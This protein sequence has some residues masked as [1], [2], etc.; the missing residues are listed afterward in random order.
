MGNY[1]SIRFYVKSLLGKKS[2]NC[3]FVTFLHQN[4]FWYH[5]TIVSTLKVCQLLSG[6]QCILILCKQSTWV[7]PF[8]SFT[9]EKKEWRIS[10][11]LT[12]FFAQF[13]QKINN[14]QMGVVILML[15]SRRERKKKFSQHFSWIFN[16]YPKEWSACVEFAA[17]FLIESRSNQ[18]S[19]V[20]I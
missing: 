15:I 8:S 2:E 6:K 18:N 16:D 9:K 3:H 5:Q 20:K 19:W 10:V 7:V 1:Q 17:L 13:S 11:K 14:F 12:P 4:I